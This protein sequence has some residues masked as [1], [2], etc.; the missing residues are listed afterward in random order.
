[1]TY[2]QVWWPILRICALHLTHPKGT[3]S[4]E[5]THTQLPPPP[6]PY[7]QTWNF[8][9]QCRP[10]FT[11]YYTVLNTLKRK[12]KQL[13]DLANYLK[14]FCSVEQCSQSKTYLLISSTQWPIRNVRVFRIHS[15]LKEPEFCTLVN[16]ACEWSGSVH[17]HLHLHLII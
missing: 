8:W 11:G 16:R 5:H 17:L 3:H 6:P 9:C 4:C 1:M 13:K 7:R 15:P 10:G 12:Q 2:G 14:Y